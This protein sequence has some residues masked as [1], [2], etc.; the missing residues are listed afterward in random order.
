M[1][2][3]R[4][5][6]VV[7]SADGASIPKE[8]SHETS[9]AGRSCWSKCLHRL[10]VIVRTVLTRHWPPGARLLRSDCRMNWMNWNFKL[11]RLVLGCIDA[12]LCNQI[13]RSKNFLCRGFRDSKDLQNFVVSGFIILYIASNSKL[14]EKRQNILQRGRTYTNIHKWVLMK[15]E[16]SSNLHIS[17]I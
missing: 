1:G 13:C 8:C 9:L 16:I 6:R 14:R 4:L 3:F 11:D 10:R 2:C 5:Q 17:A 12:D 15:F 7:F